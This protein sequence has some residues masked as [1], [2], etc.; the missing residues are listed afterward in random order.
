MA[1]RRGRPSLGERV[2][3]GLRVT[4]EMKRRLDEAARRSGRSQSQEAEFRL[5]R[6]FD[7]T[8]LLSEVLSLNYGR[9]LAGMLLLLGSAM[10]WADAFQRVDDKLDKKRRANQPWRWAP[11]A[12][13]YNAAVEAVVTILEALRPREP[14]SG[15]R[16][17]DSGRDTA[18]HLL[19]VVTDN[20]A[21]GMMD[22][23]DLEN[24]REL[25]GPRL[26][27]INPSF[28]TVT[29]QA[30]LNQGRRNNDE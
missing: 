18:A 8:D 24:I 11:D 27:C 17:R 23:A 6:S 19:K 22:D 13:S 20:T 12:D 29:K 4:P 30:I 16:G 15:R 7:R 3:L 14:I 21:T 9:D 5:E 26:K 28:A 10:L 2:P 25:L 1:K